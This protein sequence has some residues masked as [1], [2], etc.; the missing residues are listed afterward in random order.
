MLMLRAVSLLP[1]ARAL[2]PRKCRT[3]WVRD[4]VLDKDREREGPG[5]GVGSYERGQGDGGDGDE[6]R[7]GGD[8]ECGLR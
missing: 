5:L 8:D 2:K 1:S 4:D 3:V 6:G 7:K